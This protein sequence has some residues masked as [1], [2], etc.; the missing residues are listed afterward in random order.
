MMLLGVDAILLVVGVYSTGRSAG[1]PAWRMRRRWMPIT[2][3]GWLEVIHAWEEG[4]EAEWEDG[5]DCW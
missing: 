3:S 2:P 4:G 1:R 5:D